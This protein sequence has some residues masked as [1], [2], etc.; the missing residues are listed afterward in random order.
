MRFLLA[1]IAFSIFAL[2]AQAAWQ[3]ITDT[4]TFASQVVGNAY[5][6]NNGNWFRFN[7]NGTLSGGANGQDL[8]GNWQ[9]V[10]GFACFNRTLGGEPL[11]NDCIVVLVD[12]DKLVTVR[13]EGQGRQTQYTK[14]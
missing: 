12:G 6:D 14:R 2:P 5:V 10:R 7:A 11:P 1:Y 8:A 9:F 4:G 13:N 3:Q